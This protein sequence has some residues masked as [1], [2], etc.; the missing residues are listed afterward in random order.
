[1]RPLSVSGRR[2]ATR[3]WSC[4]GGDQTTSA[5]P[6]A[7]WISAKAARPSC[8]CALRMV[9]TCTTPGLTKPSCRWNGS[10]SRKACATRTARPIDPASIGVSADFPKAVPSLLTL[11]KV[12]DK[13]EIHIIEQGFPDSQ[14]YEFAVLGLQQSLE[15]MAQAL[16]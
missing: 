4:D 14:L 3:R 2:L 12:G 5:R 16:G 10:S 13:T 8:V 9:S 7:R 11:K 15:K 1:M 6:A